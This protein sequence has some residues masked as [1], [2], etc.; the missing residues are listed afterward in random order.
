MYWHSSMPT[1]FR[2]R[3]RLRIK[4]SGVALQ[5]RGRRTASDAALGMPL[6]PGLTGVAPRCKHAVSVCAL[7]SITAAELNAGV[8][9][10]D[11]RLSVQLSAVTSLAMRGSLEK[12]SRC[13]VFAVRVPQARAHHSSCRRP[14]IAESCR[15]CPLKTSC[16]IDE[17]KT[18]SSSQQPIAGCD[19]NHA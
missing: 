11:A 6:R 17:G 7:F 2:A 12:I 1:R 16:P 9:V 18:C 13:T 4:G 10:V 14:S 5:P 15:P 3:L 19:C 8:K